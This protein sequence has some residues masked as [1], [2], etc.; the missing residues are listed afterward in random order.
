MDANKKRE[1][2][3]IKKNHKNH[4]NYMTSLSATFFYYTVVFLKNV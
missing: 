1:L 2:D 3:R 4:I